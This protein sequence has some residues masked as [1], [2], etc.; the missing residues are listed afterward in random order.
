MSS[1]PND[2]TDQLPP[3]P[4]EVVAAVDQSNLYNLLERLDCFMRIADLAA[5]VRLY[6]SAVL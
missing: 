4:S 2:P 3:G 1:A 6:H 5:E